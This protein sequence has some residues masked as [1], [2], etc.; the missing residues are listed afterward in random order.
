MG[1]SI[2]LSKTFWVNLIAFAVLIINNYYPLFNLSPEVQGY[3]LI[4]I[5]FLLRLITGKPIVW[6]KRKMY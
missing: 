4:G 2:F 3:I 5:N 1:K 6:T